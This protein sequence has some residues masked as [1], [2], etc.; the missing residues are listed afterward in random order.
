[1]NTGRVN[2]LFVLKYLVLSLIIYCSTCVE[3]YQKSAKNLTLGRVLISGGR[4]ESFGG[5][6]GLYQ[7]R[8]KKS[9]FLK[10]Q[11]IF[12]MKGF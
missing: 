2:N 9:G 11:K 3:P 7:K 10:N 4:S 12:K 1:M 6:G 5:G 8:L